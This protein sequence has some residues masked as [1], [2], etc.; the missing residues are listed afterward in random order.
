MHKLSNQLKRYM[1]PKHSEIHP[2]MKEMLESVSVAIKSTAVDSSLSFAQYVDS[3]IPDKLNRGRGASFMIFESEK[4][5]TIGFS[6]AFENSC[7]TYANFGE[8]SRML[9]L[10][11]NLFFLK[12]PYQVGSI[13]EEKS[14]DFKMEELIALKLESLFFKKED[15]NFLNSFSK[16]K[17][18]GL[19]ILSSSSSGYFINLDFSS[20]KYNER[21]PWNVVFDLYF[22]GDALAIF[23]ENLAIH[24][25]FLEKVLELTFYLLLQ[26]DEKKLKKNKVFNLMLYHFFEAKSRM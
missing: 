4:S 19:S 10:V 26:A 23:G 2:I 24:V 6:M 1:S 20:Y 7:Q 25:L 16:K 5:R 9:S 14:F 21:F 11:L 13:I 12:L 18:Y 22:Q 8:L 3:I 15:V 17:K